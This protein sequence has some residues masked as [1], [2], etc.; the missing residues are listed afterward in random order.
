MKCPF[1]VAA[2]LGD[3]SLGIPA[4]RPNSRYLSFT[5]SAAQRDYLVYKV[6]R[7]NAELGTSARVSPPRPVRDKRTGKVYQSC[8]CMLVSPYLREL[9]KLLYPNGKKLISRELLSELGLEALAV[10]WMDDGCVVQSRYSH[11][12]GLLATYGDE[13]HALAHCDWI[14]SLTGVNS[15]PYRDRKHYRVRINSSEMPR[16]VR[17]IRP[18]VHSS[19]HKK[20]ALTYSSY[21]THS[22]REYEAS[23]TIPFVDK[24][25]KATRARNSHTA[26][27]IV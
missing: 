14:N 13:Q 15:V 20:V 10:Y 25:D 24:G 12:R 9:Y 3:G 22:K 19:M 11:N 5:H 6:S 8:Q 1:T 26:D 27:E 23:L 21:N 16:F 18:Y 7:I 17:S 4:D 2:V